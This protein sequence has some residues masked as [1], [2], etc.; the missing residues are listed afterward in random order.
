MASQKR[1]DDDERDRG[2]GLYY[3]KLPK[4]NLKASSSYF[5]PCLANKLQ[6]RLLLKAKLLV[7]GSQN[8]GVSV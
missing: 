4:A 6:W 5:F 7:S 8:E 3:I 1:D 2:H